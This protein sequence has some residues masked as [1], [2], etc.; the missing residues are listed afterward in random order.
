MVALALVDPADVSATPPATRLR[1]T[2]GNMVLTINRETIEVGMV[3]SPEPIAVFKTATGEQQ[4]SMYLLVYFQGSG[5]KRC[6]P[7]WMQNDWEWVLVQSLYLG[8]LRCRCRRKRTAG[9]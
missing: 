3:G 7:L 4:P 6:T 5:V 2:V 1:L 9:A 8:R